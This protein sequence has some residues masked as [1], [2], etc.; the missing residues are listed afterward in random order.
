MHELKIILGRE[1][2]ERVRTRSFVLSTLL[3][4]VFFLAILLGPI[5]ADRMGGGRDLSFALVD[6]SGTGLGEE[7][8]AAL[9]TPAGEDGGRW[10][11]RTVPGTAAA[12]QDSLAAEVLADRID[13]LLIV[14]AGILEGAPVQYRARSVTDT[15]LQ[16]RIAAVASA[17]AQGRRLESAGIDAGQLAGIMHPVQVSASRLGS[18]GGEE[19]SA[20]AGILF[21]LMIGFAL[22]MLILL[23]GVQVLQ[24]VQEEKT[25]RISEILISSM[26][27]SHLMLGKVLGVGMAALTQICIWIAL[28]LLL[29][30]PLG[31]M[32]TDGGG[33][34]SM[35]GGIL[36]QA[37]PGMLVAVLGYL[38]LGFLLYASLFAAAGAAAASSEDAQR[39]TFPLIMPLIVP[40]MVT[41]SIIS[42]PRDALAVVLSWIPFTMPIAM[43]MRLGAGGAGGLEVTAS[44]AV[45]GLSV[46]LLGVIAGKIY[47][48]GILSTGKRPTFAELVR[49]VR[50]A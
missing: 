44:L 10:T 29:S 14:P 17:A 30:R 26:R 11:V 19:Q 9:T 24:S 1:F 47:R 43:P 40:M 32:M 21:S 41:V 45:L 22:Y 48:I 27:A 38:L 23:Y 13:G 39:F 42:A 33:E 50:T 46:M 18:S 36:S 7:I 8:S 12:V 20:E 6:E 16:R 2:G 5:L 3:T 15:G 25:N 31:G 28:A 34:L 49:W 35:V 37:D 4:P